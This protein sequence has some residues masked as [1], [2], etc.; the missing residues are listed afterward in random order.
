[1]PEG[2]DVEWIK[3]KAKRNEFELSGHAHKERQEE[4]I[5]TWEIQEALVGCE[6]LESYSEDPR[7][8]SCLVLGYV[9]ERPIHV[10]CGR[11]KNDWLLIVTVYVPRSPKWVDPKTRGGREK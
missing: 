5:S 11:G 4:T 10:V 9:K 2:I 8:P 7:G 6:V 3:E 1:M